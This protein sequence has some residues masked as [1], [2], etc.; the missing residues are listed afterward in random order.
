MIWVGRHS[1]RVLS[2]F[3]GSLSLSSILFSTQKNQETPK[4]TNNSKIW[5]WWAYTHIYNTFLQTWLESQ[6]QQYMHCVRR[7]QPWAKPSKTS[8]HRLRSLFVFRLYECVCEFLMYMYFSP[9]M[10]S[11]SAWLDLLKNKVKKGY[12]QSLYESNAIC[13][14]FQPKLMNSFNRRTRCLAVFRYYLLLAILCSVP[15]IF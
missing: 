2:D 11:Q 5:W 3:L 9:H 6:D 15:S 4:P 1:L 12:E 10:S 13:V 14:N 7:W 8:I